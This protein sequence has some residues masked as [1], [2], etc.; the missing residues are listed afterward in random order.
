MVLY[1]PCPFF[2]GASGSGYP[3]NVNINLADLLIGLISKESGCETTLT[4]DRKAVKSDHFVL[5]A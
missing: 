3:S 4:F 5:I 1:K 2:I